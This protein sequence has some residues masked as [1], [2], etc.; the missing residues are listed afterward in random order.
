MQ[1]LLRDPVW[2]LHSVDFH[3]LCTST[4]MCWTLK[5]AVARILFISTAVKY[6]ETLL[7]Y[8]IPLERSDPRWVGAWWIG[9]LL[10]T[11][12]AWVLVSLPM[13]GFPKQFPGDELNR[14]VGVGLYLTY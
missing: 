4:S 10:A 12:M 13:F 5:S 11:G 9:Y 6:F 8:R 7:R 1:S 3:L 14:A 2:D